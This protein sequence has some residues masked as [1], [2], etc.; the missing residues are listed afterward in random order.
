[1]S[2]QYILLI[3]FFLHLIPHDRTSVLVVLWF[4]GNLKIVGEQKVMTDC[5]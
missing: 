4:Q 2:S 1:M 5:Q 3:H